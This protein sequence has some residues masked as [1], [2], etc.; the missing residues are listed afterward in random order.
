MDQRGFFDVSVVVVLIACCSC[1]LYI[2][3]ALSLITYSDEVAVCVLLCVFSLGS[4]RGMFGFCSVYVALLRKNRSE[5]SARIKGHCGQAFCL[6]LCVKNER[7]DQV[8]SALTYSARDVIFYK[9]ERRWTKGV[10]PE[11]DR[12]PPGSQGMNALCD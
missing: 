10:C 6:C 9:G 11:G 12:L 5:G 1:R 4:A 2:S 8:K 3:I 7:Q